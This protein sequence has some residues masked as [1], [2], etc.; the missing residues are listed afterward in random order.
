MAK[1]VRKFVQTFNMSRQI[2][3][4]QLLLYDDDETLA[5]QHTETQST[6]KRND[7]IEYINAD[8]QRGELCE[9][10]VV[11]EM[12]KP[13]FKKPKL[14][15]TYS[16][17]AAAAASDNQK[18]QRP[19]FAKRNKFNNNNNPVKEIVKGGMVGDNQHNHDT[20]DHGISNSMIK[21]NSKVNACDDADGGS[22]DTGSS[23][24]MV[25][26][27]R[28]ASKWDSFVDD[29]DESGCEEINAA[30]AFETKINFILGIEIES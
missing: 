20:V 4:N 5:Q 24:V 12:P 6:K 29:D 28:P 19:V 15:N 26:L 13:L 3:F 7:W 16:P 30:V 17:A 1:D 14:M 21:W 27:K 18:L 25:K 11:T 8:D 2:Q 23:S 22:T 10:N 9:L